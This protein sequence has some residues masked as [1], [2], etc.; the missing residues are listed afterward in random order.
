[1]VSLVRPDIQSLL[2]CHVAAMQVWAREIVFVCPSELAGTACLA[3]LRRI[4]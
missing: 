1:M 2:M 3:W 4:D